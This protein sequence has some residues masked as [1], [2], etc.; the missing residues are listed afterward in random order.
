MKQHSQCEFA[1]AFNSNR[2][3]ENPG[4]MSILNVII[5]NNSQKVIQFIHQDFFIVTIVVL[6]KKLWRNTSIKQ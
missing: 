6:K 3:T 2:V 4:R 1:I 5:N